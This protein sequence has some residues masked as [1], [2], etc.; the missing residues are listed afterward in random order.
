MRDAE[1]CER[2]IANVLQFAR[3]GTTEIWPGEINDIV[4]RAIDLTQPYATQEGAVLEVNL[5]ARLP[6]TAVNPSQMEQV[7][8]NLLKNAVESG[9]SGNRVTIRTDSTADTVRIVVTDSGRGMTTQQRSHLFDPFYTTREREGGTGLGLSI[10]HGIVLSHGG[11]I[12]V[13]SE[14]GRGTTITVELPRVSAPP[15][16]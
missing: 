1:R 8:V 6:Q 12:D 14:L 9:N 15:S 7:F 11:T 10:A 13:E 4:R 16:R 3:N 5:A 2:I